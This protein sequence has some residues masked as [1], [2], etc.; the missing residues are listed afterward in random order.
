MNVIVS[1]PRLL[2]K[3]KIITTKYWCPESLL[4][5]IDTEK[6]QQAP[7]EKRAEIALEII[8]KYIRSDSILEINIDSHTKLSIMTDVELQRL[9]DRLFSLAIK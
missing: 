4:F 9:D 3:F 8:E 5:I 2:E 1:N 7:Q 6:Y